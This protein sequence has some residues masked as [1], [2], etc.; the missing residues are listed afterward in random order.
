MSTGH[1]DAHRALLEGLFGMVAVAEE[2][3][4]ADQVLTRWGVAGHAARTVLLETPGTG[5]GVLLVAFDPPSSVVIR[6]GAA[7]HDRDALKV[8]DF[9]TTDLDR[10]IEQVRAMGYRERS[11][12]ARYSLPEVGEIAEAHVWADDGVAFAFLA[13]DLAF[14]RRAT[15]IRATDRLFTEIPSFS[16]PV[17]ALEPVV[18][19]YEQAL[20]L[21]VTYHY[22]IETPSF[23][24]LVGMRQTTRVQGF[25]FGVH[26]QPTQL[27]V[28][29]YDLPEGVSRSLRNRAVMPHR[30]VVGARL[31]VTSIEELAERCA[32]HGVEVVAP[33][34]EQ[35]IAPYGVARAMLIRA[36][37]GVL[38]H[39]L[40]R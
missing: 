39:C 12:V 20:G 28:I 11:D 24:A 22:T 6:E 34:A 14:F 16:A 27:G 26:G 7:G 33:P 36:P 31:T 13:G 21:A 1:W 17:S 5:V 19:F 2:T 35:V 23:A 40:E 25:N 18:A 8:I 15:F 3:L 37:H 32:A 38:H 4:T 30:G 10:A 9:V 29:H